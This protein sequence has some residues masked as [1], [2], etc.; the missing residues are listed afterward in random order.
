MEQGERISKTQVPCSWWEWQLFPSL[1]AESHAEP[2]CRSPG[3]NLLSMMGPLC[4][5]VCLIATCAYALQSSLALF[6]VFQQ[7]LLK[8][9]GWNEKVSNHFPWK[10]GGQIQ[11]GVPAE[12]FPPRQW[13]HSLRKHR[14]RKA[15]EPVMSHSTIQKKFDCFFKVFPPGVS[16]D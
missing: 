16:F 14:Q 8:V 5:S 11:V 15:L 13:P 9:A 10:E 7:S 1:S 6:D 12:M 4:T 2:P 3:W